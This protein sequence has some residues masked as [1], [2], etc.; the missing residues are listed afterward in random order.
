MQLILINIL[1]FP[2][3]WVALTLISVGLICCVVVPIDLVKNGKREM[4]D[5][6]VKIVGAVSVVIGFVGALLLLM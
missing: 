3:L 4:P 1:L 2:L 6:L 5:F